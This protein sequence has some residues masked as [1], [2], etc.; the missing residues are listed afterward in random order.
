MVIKSKIQISNLK[1]MNQVKPLYILYKVN[2]ILEIRVF[3]VTSALT[4]PILK[5]GGGVSERL[6]SQELLGG[7]VE[8][9]SL[10][11]VACS[12]LMWLSC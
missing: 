2:P 11:S 7:L 5:G 1:P 9:T 12:E 8:A 10:K 4:W 6:L 3:P